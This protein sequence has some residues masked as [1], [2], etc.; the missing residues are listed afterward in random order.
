VVSVN[1]TRQGQPAEASTVTGPDNDDRTP[2][3][4]IDA[5]PDMTHPPNVVSEALDDVPAA[6][7]R[8]RAGT[9][10]L[11]GYDG[12]AVDGITALTSSDLCGT[13]LGYV[14]KVVQLGNIVSQ[15][16]LMSLFH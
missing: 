13:I 8:A 3:R 15:V 16:L 6:L 10:R 12:T 2:I 4:S 5:T 11:H 7:E 14:D 1:R 9:A